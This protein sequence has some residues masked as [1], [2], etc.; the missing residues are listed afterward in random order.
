MAGVGG[1]MM[2]EPDVTIL[3]V[4]VSAISRT[5][6]DY[7]VYDQTVIKLHNTPG[8]NALILEKY[9]KTGFQSGKGE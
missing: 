5:V 4:S 1:K 3:K 8:N 9:G 7:I 2:T 6:H